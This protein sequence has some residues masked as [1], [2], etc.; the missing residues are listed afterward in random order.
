MEIEFEELLDQLQEK[1]SLKNEDFYSQ[2][3]QADYGDGN[4]KH[5]APTNQ[6]VE[7]KKQGLKNKIR[8]SILMT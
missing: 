5:M 1:R 3:L 8:Q 6:L 4:Y 7:Q 2:I